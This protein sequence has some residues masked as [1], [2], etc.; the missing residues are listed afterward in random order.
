M[1]QFRKKK[2]PP[3]SSIKLGKE[4]KK[5]QNAVTEI[6]EKYKPDV[7]NYDL[8]KGVAEK[9]GVDVEFVAGSFESYLKKNALRKIRRL[10]QSQ[11][12][13]IMSLEQAAVEYGFDLD[14]LS[15]TYLSKE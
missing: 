5:F 13:T 8:L 15:V 2:V 10:K 14:S 12:Y 1:F 9:Y 7:L 3:A 11:N 6:N 4:A